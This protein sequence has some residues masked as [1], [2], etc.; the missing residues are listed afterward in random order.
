MKNIGVPWIWK[1]VQGEKSIVQEIIFTIL[2]TLGIGKNSLTK[3]SYDGTRNIRAAYYV[4][5]LNSAPDQSY[6][7]DSLRKYVR[8]KN[9]MVIAQRE[10]NMEKAEH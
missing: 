5:I 2:K 4:Y 3:R 9:E 6:S 7:G 10:V 1:N 8:E